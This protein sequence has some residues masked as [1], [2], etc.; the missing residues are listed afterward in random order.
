MNP[1]VCIVIPAYRPD[2]R[3]LEVLRGLAPGDLPILVVDDGSGDTFQ[4]VFED[5]AA[6]P[7][8]EVIRHPDNRGK[9]AALTTGFLHVIRGS[10]EAA[11]VVT[12]DADGQHH[13]EDILKVAAELA[14]HP[15]DLVLGVRSFQGR[16]PLRSRIGNGLTRGLFRVLYGQAL[17]DT[18][19]GLRGVPRLLAEAMLS[20]A[21]SRYE[22]EL[23]ML[24]VARQLS[25][26]IR[27]VPVRTIYLDSNVSS[28]FNP[29]ADSMRIYFVLL[30][31][32][33]ASLVTAICDNIVFYAAFSASG[34]ILPSQIAGRLAAVAINYPLNLRAVF[35]LRKHDRRTI[36]RYLTVVVVSGTIS[37]VGLRAVHAAFG[38]PVIESKIL[39]ET[40]MF[41]VNFAL[42]RD[43]VFVSA[44]DRGKVT[45]W[46][47][48]YR[49][50]P[51]VSR[52]ARRYTIRCLLHAVRVAKMNG[53]S[54]PVILECGGGGSSFVD[55]LAQTV[56]P[57]AY[58]A[59][60]TN[61]LG[62]DLLRRHRVPCPI[63]P[64]EADVR[65]ARLERPADL[66]FSVGLIEHFDPDGTAEAIEAHFANARPGGWVILSFPCPTTLYRVSRAALES[67]RRWR[68]PDERPL[69]R[70]EVARTAS[71][72]GDLI[73][74]KT[75][76]PLMLTQHM[77]LYRRR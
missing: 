42:L 54:G 27:Q 47:A 19:T 71:R 3:L 57:L 69:E 35:L 29:L 33:A 36:F 66:V 62:L 52:L 72:M 15:L 32:S 70:D 61:R 73:W 6:I 34:L 21:S 16:I 74:E 31:F 60:D 13:P 38:V 51:L 25:I 8:V 22:F 55:A 53:A 23:D 65:G 39:V 77:M 50:R 63:F 7:G 43:F 59:I 64:A 41:L 67:V 4:A 26:R 30:R 46:T 45:D 37:Y 48:Y 17:A 28:H 76:W 40:L 68:F 12:A 20:A 49:N 56:A 75:L 2:R 18:Q 5:A 44:E 10:P 24:I 11:G 1:P 58:H 9:G 14:A